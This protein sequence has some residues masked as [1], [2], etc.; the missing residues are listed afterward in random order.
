VPTRRARN[1]EPLMIRNRPQTARH[2]VVN[3]LRADIVRGDYPAGS[4]L[5]QEEVAARLGVSTTPVREAFRDLL[6]EGM[7]EFDTHRGA[8]VRGLTLSDLREIYELRIVLEPMLAVRALKLTTDAQLAHAE[9]IH[10]QLCDEPNPERWAALNVAFHQA[11]NA[12]CSESRLARQ[13]NS[14]AEAATSYVAMSMHALPELMQIN[15]SDHAALLE[16]Y[17][18]RDTEGAFEKTTAHLQQTLH[19]IDG[20]ALTQ[21]GTQAPTA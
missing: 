6:A 16:L 8:I 10:A 15:N 1:M 7:I 9:E 5:R 21:P 17:R 19:S 12:P 3:M 13:V 18:K 14:L 2:Y 4:R 20:R 11:L